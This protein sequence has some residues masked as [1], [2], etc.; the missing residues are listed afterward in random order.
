MVQRPS[1]W[2]N[3]DAAPFA[4]AVPVLAWAR[5][6]APP[7][8]KG[9]RLWA[10]AP[11]STT[12]TQVARTG[13]R[14][15]R[16]SRWRAAQM[17][18]TPTVRVALAPKGVR[19]SDQPASRRL[20]PI[21]RDASGDFRRRVLAVQRRVGRPSRPSVR[22]QVPVE[23]GEFIVHGECLHGAR[24]RALRE[25]SGKL[26]VVDAAAAW[27]APLMM[28]GDMTGGRWRARSSGEALPIS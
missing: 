24:R 5:S 18:L 23:R 13:C 16:H 15:V 20:V 7:L 6:D 10:R 4:P 12:V 27:L 25:K 28:I 22:P 1:T 3:R 9:G 11:Y 21:E 8:A 2:R 19:S 14:E 17:E 26:R